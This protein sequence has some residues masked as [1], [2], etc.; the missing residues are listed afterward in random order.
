MCVCVYACEDVKS[1]D[2]YESLT[3]VRVRVLVCFYLNL[4]CVWRDVSVKIK[5]GI[6]LSV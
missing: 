4:V 5:T 3:F 2:K 6:F 1:D